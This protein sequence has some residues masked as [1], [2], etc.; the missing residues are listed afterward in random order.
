[1]GSFDY[2]NNRQAVYNYW[3]QRVRQTAKLEAVYTLG[4]RGVHDSGMQGAKNA[5]EAV[6]MMEKIIAD[7]RDMLRKHVNK[8][9]TAIPQAFT[10]YKEV[11][12]IYEQGMKLPEDITLVWPDDNYGYIH[13]LS[14]PQ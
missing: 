4:M 12:D 2:F 11:P 6:P 7:Q 5:A 1:M 13:R 10:A 8:D 9:I 3:E 14:N